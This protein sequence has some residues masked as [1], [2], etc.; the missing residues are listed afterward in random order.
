MRGFIPPQTD[1]ERILCRRV[2]DA[3]LAAQKSGAPRFLPFLSDREQLLATSVLN[4]LNFENYVFSG[5]YEN[6][7]RK[8][9]CVLAGHDENFDSGENNDGF[10]LEALK[11]KCAKSD[12]IITHRDYLGALMALNI[13]RENLGDIVIIDGGAYLFL[14]SRVL[15]LVESELR[16]AGRTQVTAAGV[17][18]CDINLDSEQNTKVT[19][20][21]SVSSL[22]LDA[23]ISAFLNTSRTGAVQIINARKVEI[24]HVQTTQQDCKVFE[25]DVFTIK[26]TGKFKLVEIG[27]KSKK[28]RTFIKFDKY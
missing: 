17:P 5:G 13:K 4:K 3:V 12:N 27:G 23:I 2:E 19:Q 28:G 9:L 7:E 6:A 20:S 25:G 18:L 11:I 8:M 26:G 14:H 1:E 21:A 24:N 16:S 22:R 15:A 10:P